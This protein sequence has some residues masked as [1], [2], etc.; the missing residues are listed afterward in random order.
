SARW[1]QRQNRDPFVQQAREGGYRARSAFKLLEIHGKYRNKLL[2]PGMTVLDLGAA[3]GSWSQV[4]SDLVK[5]EEDGI[6][7][8]TVIAVDLLDIDPLPGVS[9]LKGDFRDAK[10]ARA[11]DELVAKGPTGKLD[12]VLSDMAPSFCGTHSIDHLR[13]MSMAWDALR[14]ADKHSAIEGGGAFV[15]KLF[16]G[17]TERKFMNAL[18]KRYQTTGIN[19]PS[20][21]RKESSEMYYI[22]LD[23]RP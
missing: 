9:F 11:I 21:S 7:G 4:A 5:P 14:L 19:K 10:V 17:G 3:P 8:G 22:G 13:S 16:A 23:R 6:G 2:E 12:V 20:S 15:C 1:L 18:K